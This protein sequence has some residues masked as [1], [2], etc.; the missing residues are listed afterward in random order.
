LQHWGIESIAPVGAEL[1]YNPQ[2][3]QL[4]EGTAEAGQSVKVRYTG[5]RQG[6]KLLYRAKVSLV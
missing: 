3:H 4:I 5:Y 6:D 1:P 2:Q